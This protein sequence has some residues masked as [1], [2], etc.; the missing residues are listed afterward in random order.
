MNECLSVL[1]Y[2]PL[3]P[4]IVSFQGIDEW[5]PNS[6]FHSHLCC[7]NDL[8]VTELIVAYSLRGCSCHPCRESMITGVED[9]LV[10]FHQ[11][12]GNRRKMGCSASYHSI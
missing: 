3:P 4:K 10:T 12:S 9:Q 8:K 7:D 2:D 1:Y 11:Q 6:H 5:Y